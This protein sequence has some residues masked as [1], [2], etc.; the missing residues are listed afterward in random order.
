[1]RVLVPVGLVIMAALPLLS[2]PTLL[3]RLTLLRTSNVARIDFRCVSEYIS[4][5]KRT[6]SLLAGSIES[7]IHR[8]V[9]LTRVR[10][11]R[12]IESKSVPARHSKI[13]FQIREVSDGLMLMQRYLGSSATAID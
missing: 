10:R 6:P 13:R 7:A 3:I 1:M 12:D 5:Q 9:N 2:V 8:Q 4:V 11:L